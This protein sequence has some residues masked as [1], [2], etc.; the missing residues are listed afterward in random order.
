MQQL[1]ATAVSTL[2]IQVMIQH[3]LD[4]RAC[5]APLRVAIT[6]QQGTHCGI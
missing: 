5:G 6:H 4:P 3:V 1:A 2:L